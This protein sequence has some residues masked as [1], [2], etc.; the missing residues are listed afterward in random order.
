M[1]KERDR[2]LAGFQPVLARVL[3]RAPKSK[4][5]VNIFRASAQKPDTTEMLIYG[6]IGMGDW[7]SVG[8]S[9]KDV[10]D[11]LAN[12]QTANIDVRINSNG[13]DA[14]QGVA[15]HSLLAAHPANVTTFNDGVAASAASVILL[16]GD[17][18]A[19]ARNALMMIHDASTGTYGDQ[20]DHAISGE[21]LGKVSQ[22]I[23]DLYSV[24]AGGTADDWRA[25]MRA[26][27]WYTGK[28]AQTAGLV[29]TITN[30]DDGDSDV[31]DAARQ[32]I[33]NRYL[34]GTPPVP[35]KM[36]EVEDFDSQA[37][38]LALLAGQLVMEA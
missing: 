7:F 18:V 13:G 10:A 38:A 14:F 34:K 5:P 21:L 31:D 6:D 36:L 19:S 29:D 22:N 16:A 30:D 20:A 25:L 32:V 33:V 1:Y 28:E 26:T 23:A 37:F 15:I 24:R 11:Q 3:D 17:S 27:T 2:I 12:V 9:A 35:A 8:V 4:D